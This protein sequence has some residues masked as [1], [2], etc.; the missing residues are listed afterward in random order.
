[1]VIKTLDPDPEPYPVPDSL[2]ILDPD[3]YPYPDLD[4]LE[5]LDPDPYPD[6]DS[7]NPDPHHWLIAPACRKADPG[8]EESS[9][10]W[11]LYAEQQPDG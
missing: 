9:T 7:M 1:L 2:E 5:M 10:L 3:P 8:F 6:P 11:E 4:S